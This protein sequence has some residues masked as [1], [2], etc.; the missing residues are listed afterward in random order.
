M[1]WIDRLFGLVSTIILARLLAPDDFGVV[2]MA[3]IAI[4]LADALLDFGV[5]VAL[6]RNT[7]VRQAHYDTAWTL[8][9]IQALI[10]TLAV[11]LAAPFAADYFHDERVRPVLQVLAF[12]LLLAGCENIGIIA[13]QKG[14]Q[15]GAEFRFLFIRRVAGF[16]IT[17]SLAWLLRSYW[18]LV[19]GALSARAFGVALSYVLH[20]MRPRL[21]LAEFREIFSVSQWML[22]RGIGTFVHGNLH[23]L[24]VG[25][26]SNAATMGAYTLAD[27]I[28]AMPTGE[29]LAPLNRV[30]FPAFAQARENPQELKRLLLL[31][32][33]LQMLVAIPAAVGLAVVADDAVTVLLGPNWLMAIPFV[34]VLALAG[35]AQSLTAS[36]GYG[37]LVLGRLRSLTVLTWAQALLFAALAFS[38]MPEHQGPLAIAWLRLALATLSILLVF[39]LL[40]R[41]LPIVRPYEIVRASARPLTAAAAMAA[42]LMTLP[43]PDSLPTAMVLTMKVGLGAV[44]YMIT[45]WAAW[46]IAG[47]PDGPEAYLLGK[48]A[49]LRSR[50]RG[51]KV[52]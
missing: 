40:I 25:R 2:A 33:G 6:I 41:A 27:E 37:L 47:R 7:G 39:G 48:V 4:V 24:L 26:W 49:D 44:V 14:M 28:S 43:F 50:H 1:R 15:F 17:I 51:R 45:I 46:W 21:C 9:L 16:L 5:N 29:L 8:R 12:S 13:L 11:L 42:A 18:A 52:L 36:C 34:Q 22:V 10:A 3:S 30:L 20:P 23:R 38:L 35:V 31:A 19:I 32:Q